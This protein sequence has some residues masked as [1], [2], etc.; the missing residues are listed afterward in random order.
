M[1]TDIK[2]VN[3]YGWVKDGEGRR[4]VITS[5]KIMFLRDGKWVEVRVEQLNPEPPNEM[6]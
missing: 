6:V 3:I 4:W 2:A 1:I 5:Y